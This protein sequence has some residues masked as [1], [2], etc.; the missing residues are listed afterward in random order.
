MLSGEATCLSA[1]AKDGE[2]VAGGVVQ[3]QGCGDHWSQKFTMLV[4]AEITCRAP[5]Y[6]KLCFVEDQN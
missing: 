2:A 3:P 4:S 5:L 6:I 1:T